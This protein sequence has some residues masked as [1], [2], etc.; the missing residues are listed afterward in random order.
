MSR[1]PSLC[2][3]VAACMLLPAAPSRAA[4]SFD[5]ARAG[6]WV[7]HTVCA[8]AA[9]GELDRQLAERYG[10]MSAASDAAAKGTL[11]DAQRAWARERGACEHAGQPVA[12]L[13]QR[14]RDRIAELG[15][16]ALP[17]WS[18]EIGPAMAGIDACLAA[19]PSLGVEVAGLRREGEIVHVALRGRNGRGFACATA[20]DGSGLVTLHDA[21]APVAGPVFRRGPERPCASAVPFGGGGVLG[22]MAAHDC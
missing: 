3:A 19:T 11:R 7:E 9:L 20:P 14:Y 13:E 1:I 8:E 12:C 21:D 16:G 2:C 15:G 10:A 18:A 17:S 4:P 22:W 5:C 6:G